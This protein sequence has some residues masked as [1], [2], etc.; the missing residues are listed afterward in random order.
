MHQLLKLKIRK[1]E[2]LEP[3]YIALA[4]LA[5]SAINTLV[6]VGVLIFKGGSSYKEELSGV[7]N[8]ITQTVAEGVKDLDE[9]VSENMRHIGTALDGIR[10]QITLDRQAGKDADAA[11]LDH[12]RRVEIWARDT[13]IDKDAFQGAIDRIET[14]V[15]EHGARAELSVSQ[16]RTDILAFVGAKS[17]ES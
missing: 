9:R 13:F 3:G 1:G 6:T 4:A 16:L 14:S 12:V 15:R 10:Q 17:K 8:R 2:K 7:E 5:F 11:L